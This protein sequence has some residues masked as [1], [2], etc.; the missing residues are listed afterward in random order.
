MTQTN[1]RIR[2]AV[3]FGGRS[4]EHE[5]S[6]QSASAVMSALDPGRYEV[7]PIGITKQGHWLTSGDPHRELLA[8]AGAIDTPPTGSPV[9]HVAPPAL[10]AD[11]L[12]HDTGE[13]RVVAD[14]VFPVLHGPF[15]EDG[16]IQGL[17]DVAGIPYVGSGVL[18]SAVGMDKAMMKVALADAGLPIV[19][20]ALLRRH[21]WEQAPEAIVDSLLARFDLPIFVKPANL[22]SSVGISKVRVPR[23][24]RPALELA[25]EYDRR[26]LVEQGVDAREIE[27]SVLGNDDPIASLPGEVLPVGE[28]YD[29][30]AKYFDDRT[31]FE[32]P[33]D[34]TPDQIGDVQRFAVE[35]FRAVDC[36]G[37]ARVDFFLERPTGRFLVNEVNTIPGFTRMSVYPKLW[38]ASGLSFDAL[39]DRLVSLAIERHRDRL[40]NRIDR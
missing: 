26:A 4:G 31:R 40:R 10:V 39:V 25:F 34:L 37:M 36:A 38:A 22:G 16:A 27:I 9:E 6:L 33:A 3:L 5:I 24:L 14:V 7:I 21:A 29:Y 15:G 35:A 23:E 2:V 28:F 30:D 12:P 20:Y 13:N 8:R 18:A 32:I 11:S 1:R 19:D 17:L